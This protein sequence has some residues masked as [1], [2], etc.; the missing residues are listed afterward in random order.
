MNFINSKDHQQE[1]V[2]SKE[3]CVGDSGEWWGL[4]LWRVHSPSVG[5]VLFS[6]C[7]QV[8]PLVDRIQQFCGRSPK[9]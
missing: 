5:T 7:C 9:F 6:C 2:M 8:I 3:D 1:V 4:W